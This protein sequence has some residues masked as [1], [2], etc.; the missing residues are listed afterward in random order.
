MQSLLD[1]KFG[2]AA[3]IEQPEQRHRAA[4]VAPEIEI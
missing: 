4:A 2:G 3:E 1:Q